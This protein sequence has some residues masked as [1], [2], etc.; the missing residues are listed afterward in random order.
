MTCFQR[1]KNVSAALDNEL[2]HFL[3]R[4]RIPALINISKE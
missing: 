2:D 3:E 1:F 4:K